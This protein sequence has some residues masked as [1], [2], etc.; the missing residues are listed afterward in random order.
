MSLA[1]QRSDSVDS[2]NSRYLRERQ[3]DKGSRIIV[4]SRWGI[5]MR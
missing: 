1:M 3:S 4:G 5:Y 2:I